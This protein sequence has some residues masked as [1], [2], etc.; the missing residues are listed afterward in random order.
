[1]S[2]PRV[3][4]RILTLNGSLRAASSNGG[5]VRLA[6]RMLE[7]CAGDEVRVQHVDWIDQLPYYNEDLEA[8]LPEI[9][10]RWRAEVALTDALVLGMPEYNFGP[11]AVAKNAID[12]ASRPTSAMAL[13]GKVI[14]LLTSGGKGGGTNMQQALTPILGWFGNTMIEEPA[15]AI[16]LGATRIR[17]DGTT[18]DPE[19][20]ELVAEKVANVLSALRAR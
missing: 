11:T 1:M 2:S 10:R 15:V 6:T 9:V 16:R 3:P 18:N 7:D 12:W 14:A 20:L 19:V 8:D 17:P 4:Y 13:R 5:L